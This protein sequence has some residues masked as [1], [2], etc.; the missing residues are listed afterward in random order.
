MVKLSNQDGSQT[1]LI[2]AEFDIRLEILLRHIN[3][4][5]ATRLQ[6]DNKVCVGVTKNKQII[7][8]KELTENTRLKKGNDRLK[9]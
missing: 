9:K 3:D 2:A 8:D 1:Q 5:N 6:G 7:S 4:I